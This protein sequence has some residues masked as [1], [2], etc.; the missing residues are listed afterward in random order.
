MDLFV[1]KMPTLWSEI[2]HSFG[3]EEL[4]YIFSGKTLIFVD[5]LAVEVSL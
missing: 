4:Q 5:L 3:S 1:V 2:L